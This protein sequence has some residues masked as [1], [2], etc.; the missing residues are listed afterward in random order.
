MINFMAIRSKLAPQRD[1]YSGENLAKLACFLAMI[2]HVH[3][4]DQFLH[5]NIR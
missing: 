5:L 4:I 3:I 1:E 2:K